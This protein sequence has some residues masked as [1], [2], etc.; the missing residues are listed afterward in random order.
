MNNILNNFLSSRDSSAKEAL[1]SYLADTINTSSLPIMDG[2]LPEVQPSDISDLAIDV[3]TDQMFKLTNKYP[4]VDFEVDDYEGAATDEYIQ[5]LHGI[6]VTIGSSLFEG[7]YPP[8]H[9]EGPLMGFFASVLD[10][11]L[12]EDED[13]F[14]NADNMSLTVNTSD[15]V[16]DEHFKQ[17]MVNNGVP[18]TEFGMLDSSKYESLYDK[19]VMFG[20]NPEACST[21][22][23]VLDDNGVSYKTNPLSLA[24][25]EPEYDN[26][27]E[28]KVLDCSRLSGKQICEQNDSINYVTDITK[29]GVLFTVF[30]SND[31]MSITESKGRSRIDHINK[32]K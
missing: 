26:L 24:S 23:K 13:A 1:K 19:V 15:F 28:M 20:D 18:V 3:Y 31:P 27:Y 14:N 30:G 16:D 9:K 5:V 2:K 21:C 10:K 8:K 7:T 22:M 12:Y 29:N 6:A 32:I 17:F 4:N 25:A 11:G